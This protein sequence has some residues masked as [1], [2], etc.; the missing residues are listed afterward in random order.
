MGDLVIVY[1]GFNKQKAVTLTEKASL[2]GGSFFH[3][4]CRQALRR[5]GVRQGR[6]QGPVCAASRPPPQMSEE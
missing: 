1:E 4:E 6:R 2:A 5:Q 3:R